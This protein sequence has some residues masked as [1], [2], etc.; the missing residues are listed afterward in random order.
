[1]A[2]APMAQASHLVDPLSKKLVPPP[3]P[4]I[5]ACGDA[6]LVLLRREVPQLHLPKLLLRLLLLQMMIAH[7]YQ[8][9]IFLE[10]PSEAVPTYLVAR[11]L[12]TA[13]T[14]IATEIGVNG[15]MVVGALMAGMVGV[16][17]ITTEN[18][19]VVAGE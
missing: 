6:E 9:D 14:L 7:H 12:Q 17:G 16:K 2:C 5:G 19:I 10:I 1:M 3:L 11:H 13:G 4:M 18:V 15:T 8:E